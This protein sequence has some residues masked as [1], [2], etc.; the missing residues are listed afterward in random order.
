MNS[1]FDF[2][3]NYCSLVWMCHGR[4]NNTKLN[5]LHERCLRPIYSDKKSSYEELH[6]K[7][8]SVPIHH[9]NIRSLA[10]EM[11][12]VKSGCAPKIFSNLFNQREISPCNLRRHTEFRVP[13]T[14]TVYHGSESISSLGPKIWDVLPTSF[15]EAATLNNF[16]K[17]I[18]K[19]IPQAYSCKLCKNYIRLVLL[20]TYHKECSFFNYWFSNIF[21]LM[22]K[23]IS[24]FSSLLWYI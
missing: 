2:H 13:L 8:G 7:D 24:T 4:R 22:V 19:W 14:R 18:K 23:L 3:F 17:L 16:K 20:K 10:I 15:K 11:Y 9:S 1:F 5:N 6:G 12:K 21:T